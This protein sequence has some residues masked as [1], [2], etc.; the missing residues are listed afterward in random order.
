M[1]ACIKWIQSICTHNT[2]RTHKQPLHTLNAD[3]D[4]DIFK[5]RKQEWVCKQEP[6]TMSIV[7]VSHLLVTAI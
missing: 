5:T 6:T 2:C 4:D 1:S 3:G 7:D